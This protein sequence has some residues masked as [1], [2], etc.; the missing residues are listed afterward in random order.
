MFVWEQ[1]NGE[2]RKVEQLLVFRESLIPCEG[3]GR[4]KV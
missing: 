4:E 1:V 3:E 2:L